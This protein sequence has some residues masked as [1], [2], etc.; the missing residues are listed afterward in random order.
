M[1]GI[2]SHK[3]D[4]QEVPR[5]SS[6]S[7]ETKS[8]QSWRGALSEYAGTLISDFQPPELWDEFLLFTTHLVC[9]ILL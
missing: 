1:S 8:L 4:A 9:G 5:P 2:S 6:S 3:I 7:E